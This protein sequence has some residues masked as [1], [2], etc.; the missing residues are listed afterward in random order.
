MRSLRGFTL[1]ELLIVIAV[2][3][4][5]AAILFP[6]LA[7]A[8]RASKRTSALSNLKQIGAAV[9]LYV[10]DYDDR[11]PFRFHD[12]TEWP[13]YNVIIFTTGPGFSKYYGPYLKND[14]IWYS[15][16]DRLKGQSY[17]SFTFNEQLAYS[18]ALSSIARP[19]EAIYATDRTDLAVSPHIVDT[20][21][22]WQFLTQGPFKESLLPGQIDPVSVASQ[23]DPIRYAGNTGLYLFLDGHASSLQFERT[24]GDAAHNLHLATKS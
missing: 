20:Y 10:N 5:L 3:S 15:P 13:G 12:F 6:V 17:T 22:W 24:W 11:L 2:I 4:L 19:A 9:H 21:T 18:W 14:Q 1:I 7:M 16:E 8:K 23:I